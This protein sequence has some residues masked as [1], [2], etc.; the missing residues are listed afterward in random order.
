MHNLSPPT[1]QLD[2]YWLGVVG[3][4][5]ILQHTQFLCQ[6]CEL[7]KRNMHT[8]VEGCGVVVWFGKYTDIASLVS[9]SFWFYHTSLPRYST[10]CVFLL[11]LAFGLLDFWTFGLLCCFHLFT[12][13]CPFLFFPF[14]NVLVQQTRRPL[15][16]PFSPLHA[17]SS[18]RPGR[19]IDRYTT[20]TIRDSFRLDEVVKK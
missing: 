8:G 5:R 9:L 3:K 16:W 11:R 20:N 15:P 12:F 2:S 1:N 6:F 18:E 17:Q 13:S 7:R 19:L 4:T 14:A 10:L